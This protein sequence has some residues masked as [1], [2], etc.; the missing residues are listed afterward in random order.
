MLATSYIFMSW[1]YRDISYFKRKMIA[2]APISTFY[3][4]FCCLLNCNTH[5]T[6]SLH[7]SWIQKLLTQNKG[8]QLSTVR[9]ILVMFTI[10]PQ[11]N[12]CLIRFNFVRNRCFIRKGNAL[13]LYDSITNENTYTW[14]SMKTLV[15]SYVFHR[16]ANFFTSLEISTNIVPYERLYH[17]SICE[18]FKSS[19]KK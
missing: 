2:L 6:K 14:L 1:V 16:M 11:F 17:Q 7:I 4:P 9:W 13:L 19:G 5:E 10:V 12:S 15:K 18:S 8:E 3:I